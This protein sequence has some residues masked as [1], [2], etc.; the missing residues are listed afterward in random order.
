MGVRPYP[1]CKKYSVLLQ[2]KGLRSRRSKVI[3]P[4]MLSYVAQNLIIL[5]NIL[6]SHRGCFV[7]SNLKKRDILLIYRA[8][9]VSS[10]LRERDT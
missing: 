1:Y 10:K 8:C 6:T 7:S 5:N 4:E 2:P 3:S 9:F